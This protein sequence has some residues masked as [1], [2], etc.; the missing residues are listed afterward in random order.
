MPVAKPPLRFFGGLAGALAPFL[1]FLGGVAW[2]GLS[3]APDERGL[4][5][6]LLAAL[7]L[8]LLLARDRSRYSEHVVEG[9]ARP[10]VA[11]MIL[12]WLLAHP[13]GICPIIGSTNPGRIAA[14]VRALDVD[15]R[16]EDWYRLLEAR[17]GQAVP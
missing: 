15:Y 7:A 12:A 17:N 6:V 3:G 13:A 8:G 16:R 5:P 10:L 1:L 9:M 4:W 2:L 11:V 14:A